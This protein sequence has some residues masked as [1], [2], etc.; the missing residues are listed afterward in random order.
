MALRFQ[1][2]PIPFVAGQTAGADAALIQPPDVIRVTNGEFGDRGN[3]RAVDGLRGLAVTAMTGETAPDDTNPTLR[4]LLSHKDELLLETFKGTF[5]QQV[6]GSF[7]LAAG[8][9]NRKRDTL[10]AMRMGVTSI[11]DSHGA[12]GDDWAGDDTIDAGVLGVD[13]AQLGDYTCTVWIEKYGVYPNAFSQMMWQIRHKTSDALVGRGR[14]RDGVTNVVSEPRVVAFGGQFRIF[15]ISGGDLGYLF[16]DPASTQNVADAVTKYT[17]GGAFI[18]MDVAVSPSHFCI[19]GVDT[20][21]A[22][23]SFVLTQAAPTVIVGNPR[24]VVPGVPRCVGNMYVNAGAAGVQQAFVAFYNCAG[25]LGT[26]RWFAVSTAGVSLGVAAQ[27]LAVDSEASRTAQTG[28]SERVF[29]PEDPN[30]GK[31]DDE[32]LAAPSGSGPSAEP[33]GGA[34]EELGGCSF[35]AH[36]QAATTSPVALMALTLLM[37]ALGSRRRARATAGQRRA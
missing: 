18:F 10:R 30:S 20:G 31:T 8:S 28:P 2:I 23:Q 15:A 14:V 22:I 25:S 32:T 6:G 5:R 29:V 4:R 35:T 34:V 24:V 26:L 13:A 3:I 27:A 37:A 33:T 12:S 1:D 19:T 7:A 11:A 16:I 17:A 36:Q 21:P 9:N